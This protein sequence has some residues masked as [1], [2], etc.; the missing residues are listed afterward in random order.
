MSADRDRLDRLFAEV[1]VGGA[2]EEQVERLDHVR[3]IERRPV[4]RI[5]DD[6]PI[7]MLRNRFRHTADEKEGRRISHRTRY[8]S[9]A[10]NKNTTSPGR[11]STPTS[12]AL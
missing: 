6:R 1:T 8:T 3:A 9:S 7:E 12:C 11:S 5:R 2:A 10:L 4:Q